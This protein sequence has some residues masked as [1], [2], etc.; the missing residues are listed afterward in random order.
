[1]VNPFRSPLADE[2][3]REAQKRCCTNTWLFESWNFREWGFQG[4]PLEPEENDKR[5]ARFV[6][7]QVHFSEKMH[8][9]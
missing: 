8:H 1:K 5:F 2:I 6:R 7:R 9:N 4:G 3:S